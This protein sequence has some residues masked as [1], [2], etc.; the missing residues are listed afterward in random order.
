MFVL[1]DLLEILINLIL[2]NGTF[3]LPNHMV[4]P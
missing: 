2:F 3:T 4:T 1:I